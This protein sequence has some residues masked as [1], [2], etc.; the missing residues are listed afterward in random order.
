[1][2]GLCSKN[3]FCP[4][5]K[6]KEKTRINS[7]YQKKYYAP[8][9]PY[10]RLIESNAISNERKNIMQNQYK[11]LDPFTIKARI[12]KKLKTFFKLVTV[13]QKCEEEIVTFAYLLF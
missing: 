3:Y 5:I 12:V 4:S 7:R 8:Q 6:L 10:Q 13:T 1:M 2:N 9:T 11:Q